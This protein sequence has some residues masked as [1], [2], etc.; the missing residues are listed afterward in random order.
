MTQELVFYVTYS[1][2]ESEEGGR[3]VKLRDIGGGGGSGRG[4]IG[5]KWE[6]NL[7]GHYLSY[8]QCNIT[9][10]ELEKVYGF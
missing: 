2:W 10:D 5:H 3:E 6:Q 9:T 4:V 1:E 7:G 8:K